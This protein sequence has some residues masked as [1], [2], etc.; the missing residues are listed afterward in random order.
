MYKQYFPIGNLRVLMSGPASFESLDIPVIF[1]L[2][3][4][5]AND[6]L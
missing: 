3:K 6:V 2:A 5:D 1:C 4:K